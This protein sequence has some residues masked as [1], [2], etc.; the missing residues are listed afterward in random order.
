MHLVDESVDPP[1][2]HELAEADVDLRQIRNFLAVAEERNFTRAAARL[3]ISQSPLSQQIR[4]LEHELKVQLFERTT[5]AV[6]LTPA[7][8]LFRERM[9]VMLTLTDEAIDATR[10]TARGETGRLIIGFSDCAGHELAQLS[11][12]TFTSKHRKSSWTCATR[13]TPPRWS[14]VCSRGASTSPCSGHPCMPTGSPSK[15]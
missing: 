3:N 13:C 9:Q 11:C 4:R 7:G 12:A 15:S 10:K 8:Q 1:G 2:S 5:R 14:T 6:D